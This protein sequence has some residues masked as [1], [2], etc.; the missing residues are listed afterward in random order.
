M[1]TATTAQSAQNR[2]AAI[3]GRLTR[4]GVL[5]W[6][7]TVPAAVAVAA[8]CGGES[9]NDK[10]A[11]YKGEQA[12]NTAP[13]PAAAAPAPPLAGQILPGQ[14]MTVPYDAALKPVT[15]EPVKQVLLT[16]TDDI[17][18]PL[19]K[20]VTYAGWGFNG[21]IPG[22]PLRVRQGDTVEATLAN[23]G[24]QGHSIDFHAAQTPW[25]RDFKTILPGAK[26][27][28][29]LEGELSRLLPVPLR[30]AAGAAPHRQR[31]VGVTARNGKN[32][33]LSLTL[34]IWR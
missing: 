34:A 9:A 18:V 20:E 14:M 19:T 32:R 16:A 11:A 17:L 33:T 15:A 8:A 6:L 25:D 5:G 28:L 30:H 1:G 23:K 26:L 3:R 4:R 24:T 13:A 12:V 31:H 7:V 29:H 22:P 21:S 2:G 10:L 27:H